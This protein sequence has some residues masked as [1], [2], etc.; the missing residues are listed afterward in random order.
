MLAFSVYDYREDA[1]S[2]KIYVCEDIAGKEIQSGNNIFSI[3]TVAAK[4]TSYSKVNWLNSSGQPA[5]APFVLRTADGKY[6]KIRFSDYNRQ[7]G[8]IK[9]KYVYAP[10]G[11]LKFE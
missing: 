4:T 5:A 7:D 2:P 8:T 10:D 11:S 3:E 9:M 6:V 1:S